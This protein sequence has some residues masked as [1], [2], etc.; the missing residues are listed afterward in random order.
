MVETQ[1][2]TKKVW[3]GVQP[4]QPWLITAG[5][6]DQNYMDKNSQET[7]PQARYLQNAPPV[8]KWTDNSNPVTSLREKRKDN[9]DSTA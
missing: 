1:P 2:Q 9:Q 4:T 8:K 5:D 3:I 7:G 6:K